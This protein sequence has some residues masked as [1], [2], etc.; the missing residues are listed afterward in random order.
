MQATAAILKPNDTIVVCNTNFTLQNFV[1]ES[2][3]ASKIQHDIVKKMLIK[4]IFFDFL[5]A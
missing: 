4:T 2:K 1:P 5:F 3:R